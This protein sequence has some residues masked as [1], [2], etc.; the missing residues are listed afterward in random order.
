MKY[1]PN[2]TYE[3]SKSLLVRSA[4]SNSFTFTMN[5]A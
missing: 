4:F 3:M 5:T 1:F 2:G